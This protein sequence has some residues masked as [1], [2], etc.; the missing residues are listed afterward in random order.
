MSIGAK[1]KKYSSM[2]PRKNLP[3]KT[4]FYSLINIFK[5]LLTMDISCGRMH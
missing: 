5:T 2:D 4:N 3:I 1:R